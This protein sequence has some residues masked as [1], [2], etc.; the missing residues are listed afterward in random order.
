[1]ELNDLM[2]GTAQCPVRYRNFEFIVTVFTEAFTPEYKAR[3]LTLTSA[4]EKAEAG[5]SGTPEQREEAA[6]MLADLIESWTDKDGEAVV[7]NG[8]PFPPT[9]ENW[10][11]LSYPM[12]GA[13][14]KQIIAFIGAE[15]NPPSAS[16]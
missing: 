10:I 1:M 4:V 6:Q 15:A 3:L 12:M 16:N 9:Y 5:E 14:T 8:Q 2:N 11:K 7:M 13:F